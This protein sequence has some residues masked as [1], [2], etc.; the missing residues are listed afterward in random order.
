MLTLLLKQKIEETKSLK[1][2]L[3]KEIDCN[4][5]ESGSDD[6]EEEEEEHTEKSHNY[7]ETIDQYV[8]SSKNLEEKEVKE[9]HDN[10]IGPSKFFDEYIIFQK[11]FDKIKISFKEIVESWINKLNL[12]E[13]QHLNNIMQIKRINIINN[14]PQNPV[15]TI[16]RKVVKIKRDG[17]V[18]VN[19]PD[20]NFNNTPS[21][22]RNI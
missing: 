19:I 17:N 15:I 20:N 3:K 16:P 1:I 22:D 7:K 21:N 13:R 18:N 2:H 14:N 6:S 9:I 11:C 5:I 12:K 10:L 8:Q 4:F